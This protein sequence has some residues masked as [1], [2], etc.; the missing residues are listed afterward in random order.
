[1]TAGR[2]LFQ[3][4]DDIITK[5]NML[6]YWKKV[7]GH[8]QQPGQDKDY[9]DQTDALAKA[10]TLHGDP[11]TFEPLPPSPSFSVITCHQHATAMQN[12]ASSQIS[13]SKMASWYI[14][15]MNLLRPSW[16][17]LSAKGW[18]CSCMLTMHHVSLG[19]NSRIDPL[20]PLC[21]KR[22]FP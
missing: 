5:H 9:N 18:S 12:P 21:P 16:W 6:V 8:S 14:P 7:R 13:I 10:G 2:S 19:L 22:G 1:M 17:P 4:C 20:H 3:A 15:L 11:W